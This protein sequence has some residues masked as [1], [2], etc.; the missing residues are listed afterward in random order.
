MS[1]RIEQISL[2]APL[3]FKDGGSGGRRLRCRTSECRIASPGCLA[4]AGSSSQ[5]AGV[6]LL[7]LLNDACSEESASWAVV[8]S[9]TD[10][11]WS[12]GDDNPF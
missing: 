5:S 2:S 9:C 12:V 8:S 11:C 7:S 4:S 6:L 3:N 10:A 1:S